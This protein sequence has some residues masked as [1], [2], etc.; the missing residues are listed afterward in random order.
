MTAFLDSQKK[1]GVDV[2]S[3]EAKIDG[4]DPIQVFYMNYA[5]LWGQNIRE[6]EMRNL[7]ISD[8][9]SLGKNRVNVSLKNIAPFFKAF[10][11]TEGDPMFRPESERIIIW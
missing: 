5:N 6:A 7:T 11:I 9:H 10:G 3:E 1:K 2:N 8:V 4:F